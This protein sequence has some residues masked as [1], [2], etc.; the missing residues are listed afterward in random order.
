MCGEKLD[1]TLMAGMSLSE[2]LVRDKLD[3]ARS[4][5]REL[6]HDNPQGIY[7]NEIW[8]IVTKALEETE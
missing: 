8:A 1:P 3:I 4:A 5:L 2:K 7:E 6:K